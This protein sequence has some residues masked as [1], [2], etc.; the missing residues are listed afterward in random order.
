M[1]PRIIHQAWVGPHQIPDRER[2]WCAEMKAMNPEF[3]VRLYGN[4]ILDHYRGD[5]YLR[6]IIDRGQPWAF[7]S[8]RLR[9]LLLRDH[10]G[11]WL[12]CDCQP[13]R[14]LR[15]LNFVWDAQHVTFS[16]GMR[17][18]HRPGVALNRGVSL[19]DNTYLA[20]APNGRMVN[21]LLELWTPKS[22][23]VD[24]HLIGIQIMCY[25]DID[26]APLNYRYFY[27]LLSEPE[28]VVLHD[29]HNLYTW[30]KPK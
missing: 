25:L 11:I 2:H 10:G 1:I 15:T 8:D 13:I 3:D 6:E 23:Q 20:S 17:N 16:Y 27:A 24:G 30:K 7:V 28:S 26:C 12:D 5:I 4:E 18:P 22:Y 21:R 14:P 29:S 19:I 9:V